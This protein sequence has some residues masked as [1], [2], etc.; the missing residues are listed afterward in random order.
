MSTATMF[1][2]IST[3][4]SERSVPTF[5][6][7]MQVY[8]ESLTNQVVAALAKKFGF[9]AQEARDYLGVT[10]Q[11]NED[12]GL[13][14]DQGSPNVAT[15]KVKSLV[16]SRKQA[17]VTVSMDDRA[18]A[19]GSKPPSVDKPPPRAAA[20]TRAPSNVDG[21]LQIQTLGDRK[22]SRVNSRT[23]TRSVSHDSLLEDANFEEMKK[24]SHR[25]R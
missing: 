23:R 22:L 7:S 1:N 17:G 5:E 12:D 3:S 14:S 11:S 19:V 18:V 9:D 10:N 20:V 16:A 13:G 15:Q 8:G 25:G 24:G 4:A 2:K 21:G 6:Q